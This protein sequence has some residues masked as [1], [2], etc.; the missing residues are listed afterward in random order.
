MEKRFF[1]ASF[2]Y[3]KTYIMPIHCFSILE[4]NE[5]KYIVYQG[6]RSIKD[7]ILKTDLMKV[8]HKKHH[9]GKDFL[10]IMYFK[11]DEQKAFEILEQYIDNETTF[12][13]TQRHTG[14]TQ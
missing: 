12:R 7:E 13:L 14:A 2:E 10:L 11:E 6:H 5:K 8:L 9:D 1:G 3:D 4:E